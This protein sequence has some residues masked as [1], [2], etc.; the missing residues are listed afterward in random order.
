[1]DKSLLERRIADWKKSEYAA[2]EAEKL[3]AAGP[4][5]RPLAE[6]AA[7]LRRIADV[8]L[9]SIIEDMRTNKATFSLLDSGRSGSGDTRAP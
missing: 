5:D 3:A 2:R 8:V 6:R 7:R 4:A 1:M 9:Q